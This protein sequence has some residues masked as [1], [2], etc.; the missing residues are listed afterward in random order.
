[1]KIYL[2]FIPLLLLGM[3]L[4]S[5]AAASTALSVS[6]TVRFISPSDPD[7][8][9]EWAS[10]GGQ[11]GLEVV[12]PDLDVEVKLVNTPNQVHPDCDECVDAEF[13]TLDNRRSFY[14]SAVPVLDS[15]VESGNV[16]T[17]HSDGFI[18]AHD[19]LLVDEDGVELSQPEVREVGIDGR[20]DLVSEFT[21]SFYA[22]YW[23]WN[24][25]DTG[26][27]VKVKS[28][29]DPVGFTV[30]LRE[31][32]SNSGVFRLLIDTHS[33]HKEPESSPPV[34]PVGKNDVITLTYMDEDP[35]RNVSKRLKVE[36]TPPAFSNL[37]PDHGT[38]DRADPIIEF[39]VTDN[40][41]G[42]TDESDIW[43]IFA[44]DTN[45]NGIIDA[46]GEHEFQ[47]N[48]T[49]RGD[50]S[51]V[52][53][54]FT[55]SLALPNEIEVDSDATIYWWAL[56]RDLAGNLGI[57]DRQPTI[58][59]RDNLCFP[60]EFPR[61]EL[62]GANVNIDHN[63]AGCQPYT[64][65]IDN[66]GPV[67]V[68]IITGRWW[69]PSKSGDD[70]TEY[71]STKAK[72]TSILV[73][74]SEDLDSST[75]QKTDFLVDGEV[76]MKAEVF[77]GRPDYIFLTVSPLSAGAEPEVEVTG[78]IFD[79]AGNHL[80]SGETD[81]NGDSPDPDPPTTKESLELLV[82]VLRESE[83]IGSFS[84]DLGELLAELFIEDLIAPA[85]EETPE[86]VETRI[87]ASDS[88]LSDDSLEYLIAVL[89]E[90][91]Q[92]GAWSDELSDMLSDLLI[93]YLIVPV[94]GETVDE[95]KDRLSAE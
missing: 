42:I 91:N 28:Q 82:A 62:E 11:V 38:A 19:I 41:S 67:V 26:D 64:A 5:L 13:I 87:L 4:V 29:A 54:V 7:D 10:Q 47:V 69:D 45:S 71:D 12:D 57:L 8:E 17:G 77:S 58:D 56:A 81:E 66:S 93:E 1:M 39:D 2:R 52:N 75:V 32:R 68:R 80:G 65:I 74:F 94:T 88:A 55:A 48:D 24:I 6:G 44:V 23:G 51:E 90:S 61:G 27:L 60:T 18:N 73:A 84:E 83:E 21:G 50:V 46:N 59:G 85:T 49:A 79:V 31:T 20:V 14:L 78:S 53:G 70:K 89:R 35:D 92:V 36:S 9:Q 72:N 86:E 25:G 33:H 15:G 43:I 3:F 16:I 95:V 63:V 22:V 34:L 76:P 37:S 30:K 40:E